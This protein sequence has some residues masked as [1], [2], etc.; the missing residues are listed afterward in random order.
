MV[1][2]P[3]TVIRIYKN[4]PLDGTYNHTLLFTSA[5]QQKAYFSNPEHNIPVNSYQRVVSGKM[6]IQKRAE[7]LYNCNYLSFQNSNYGTK[8]FYAFITGVEFIN[9]ETSEITFEIDVMQTYLFDV[10]LKQC[11]VVREHS[12]TDNIGENIKPEQVATG[13]YIF[14]DYAPA[15]IMSE[16]CVILAIVDV[17]TASDGNLYDGIYGGAKL[18]AFKS[19]DVQGINTKIASYIQKPESIVTAYMCPKAMLPDVPTGGIVVP[20]GAN[21]GVYNILFD[22]ITGTESFGNYVPKNKKLYTYPFNYFNIDNASGQSLPLRYE[23]FD[24]LTPAITIQGTI[25]QPVKVICRP[26]SYKG[27]PSYSEAGGYTSLNT[28]SITIESYPMCSWN[29]DTFKQWVAQNSVPLALNTVS[30]IAN[31]TVASNYSVYP[32]ASAITGTLGT[33]TGLLAQTYSASIAADTCRGTF[34]NGCVNVATGKQQFYKSRV[35][36]TENFARMIDQ[37]FDMFGYTCNEIKIPNRDSRPHWNFV[38]TNGCVLQGN[39]PVDYVRKICS[40]YDTGITFWKN[41]DDVGN[42]SL[43]NRP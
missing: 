11:F 20:Y 18:W 1:I 3:N 35:H 26:I 13:E 25:T 33:V 5:S 24:N 17:D 22:T 15:M 39:A 16:F 7:Q 8:W 10:T 41:A 36:V 29:T 19:T 38:K 27:V 2:E 42:Y 34:N 4:I 43:D 31:A 6:R 40:I 21:G 12:V 28:E 37:Y 14:S 9:N 30:N 23:F 32:K